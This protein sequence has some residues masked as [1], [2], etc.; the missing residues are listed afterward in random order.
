MLDPSSLISTP[1]KQSSKQQIGLAK[2]NSSLNL[3]HY[4]KV[5]LP[6]IHNGR[7]NR[8]GVKVNTS[9]GMLLL[10]ICIDQESVTEQENFKVN[11][12]K[13]FINSIP[14]LS[15]EYLQ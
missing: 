12:N 2:Y 8:E 5:Q 3:K 6:Q 13:V 4:E 15:I 11:Y 9:E 1:G 7:N 14:N 10:E